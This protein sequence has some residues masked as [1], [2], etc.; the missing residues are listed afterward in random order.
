MA[1]RSAVP[2]ID[3]HK[4]PGIPNGIIEPRSKKRKTN[5]VSPREYE[6]LRE[7]A[8]G[9]Q[10][11]KDVIKTD[12]APD[13]DPWI[14]KSD[15]EEQDPRFS[16]LEKA[17]PIRAPSTI[18][19]APIS[20]AAGKGEVP[21]VPAPKPG[22][23][24][25]PVFEDWDALLITEGQKEVE[26]EKKRLLEAARE[27]EGLARIAA[28]ENEPEY[29]NGVQ[30]EEESAW[31]GFESEY[32]GAEWLKKKRSERKTPAERNRINR[33]KEAERREKWEKKEREKEKQERRVA[34]IVKM[35]KEEAKRRELMTVGGETEVQEEVDD[36]VLRRRKFGK[37]AYVY[38][39]SI[40]PVN[41]TNG[42]QAARTTS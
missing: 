27:Q 40:A 18:K 34:E 11:V 38:H 35:A 14:A 25:N 22:T 13:Y 21:A 33:K 1:Q 23:S 5:G 16:Y 7:V 36:R 32:E 3:S 24:Y 26:A 6:R 28:A 37:D 8:Y 12:D 19:E 17:K 31:E 30:T 29:D 41:A 42:K 10:T 9:S 2:A 39:A 15:E 20:L 4:R